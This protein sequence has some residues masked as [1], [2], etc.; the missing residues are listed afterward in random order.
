MIASILESIK[1][2]LNID[3]S[4]TNFDDELVMHINSA[5]SQLYQIGAAPKD[6]FT[7]TG[8]TEKWFDFLGE[9]KNVEHVKTYVYYQVKLDFDPPA[10]SFALTAAQERIKKLEWL[11]QT[12]EL[13]FNPNAWVSPSS[14]TGDV[15]EEPTFWTIDETQPLPAEMK[16]GEVG[17]D[18]KTGN[19]VKKI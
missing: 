14:V 7:I 16:V 9:L 18:P 12:L 4:E 11:L 6:G 10:T 3:E 1:R 13:T 5:F 15:V 2:P 17:Y 8:K 19:L